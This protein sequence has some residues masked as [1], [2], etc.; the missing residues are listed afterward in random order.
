MRQLACAIRV[1][2]PQIIVAVGVKVDARILVKQV[3]ERHIQLIR[4]PLHAV[5]V[6]LFLLGNRRGQ[7]HQNRLD[8]VFA[9]IGD[10]VP[11]R[12]RARQFAFG[13]CVRAGI[14]ERFAAPD[15]HFTAHHERFAVDHAR[16]RAGHQLFPAAVIE[17]EGHHD[18]HP[19]LLGKRCANGFKLPE[20]ERIAVKEK[21]AIAV[22]PRRVERLVDIVDVDDRDFGLMHL[23][24][25]LENPFRHAQTFG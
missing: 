21:M 16:A 8:A 2:V 4:K 17:R 15:A 13:H 5:H 14:G 1:H 12:M 11:Q 22:R 20:G 7:C 18:L 3:E 9:A 10:D 19:L 23:G 6:R 24:S 25:Q